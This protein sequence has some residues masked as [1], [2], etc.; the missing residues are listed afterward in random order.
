MG[1]RFPY[2]RISQHMLSLQMP[3]VADDVRTQWRSPSDILSFLLLLGPDVIK[4]ALAQLT[5]G[6][7]VP[8]A[9]S[10]GWVAYSV[11]ALLS[12]LG[13]KTTSYLHFE[14]KRRS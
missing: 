8:I 9:F 1:S 6:P 11:N 7:I 5:G 14:G 4:Q 13:G 2:R 10:F 3:S 12:V